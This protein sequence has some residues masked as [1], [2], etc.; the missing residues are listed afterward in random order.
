MTTGLAGSKSE[1]RRLIDQGG[2]RVNGTQMRPDLGIR[3]IGLLH[4][5]FA[6]L[7]KGRQRYHL[8]EISS[9]TG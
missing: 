9:R 7:R 2:V 6:L 5:R 8:V 4:E 3:D 1:A